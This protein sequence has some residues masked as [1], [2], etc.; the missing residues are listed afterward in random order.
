MADRTYLRREFESFE[1]YDPAFTKVDVPLSAN[2]N[3]FGMPEDVHEAMMAAASKVELNRY[4]DPMA[5]GL[6]DE[7]AAWR[8][9]SREQVIVGNGGDELLFNFLLACGGPERTL[10]SCP[11]QFSIYDLYAQMTGTPVV[12]VPRNPEDFEIDRA[13]VEKAAATAGLVIL[14]SPNNP[15]GNI[16]DPDWVDELASDTD[17]LIMIDEAYGE[18]DDEEATCAGLVSKHDNV[19]VLHTFSKAFC[20]AGLRCGYLLAPE[21]LVDAMSAVRQ[22]YSVDAVSQAIAT[23]AV[24]RREAFRPAIEQTRRERARLIEGLRAIDGVT[25]WDSHANFFC[26]RVAGAHEVYGRLRDE[27]SILVRDFSQTPGIEDCLRI[28]VGTPE[29]NDKV[30]AAIKTIVGSAS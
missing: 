8:G 23:V 28:T 20:L 21:G 12:H 18:Y 1:P 15:T 22:P 16:V 9:V 11:P 19:V 13:G 2:E 17:A 30:I 6:R 4:P 25:A 14:T 26:I 5:N 10:V 7:V 24:Q 29:E 27:F 3:S